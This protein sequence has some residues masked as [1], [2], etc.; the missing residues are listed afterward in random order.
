VV[1]LLA[2]L[3]HEED[4]SGQI[5][6]LVHEQAGR[7]AEHSDVEVVTAGVHGSVDSRR[8][9]E[10]GVFRHGQGVHVATEQDRRAGAGPVEYANDA[11]G[12]RARRQGQAEPVDRFQDAVLRAGQVEAD[13]GLPV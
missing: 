1:A 3:E 10:P 6:T 5:G 8:V 11:R 7:R 4:S 2:G 9:G 12:A 13:L